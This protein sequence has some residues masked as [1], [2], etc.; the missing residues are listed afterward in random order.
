MSLTAAGASGVCSAHDLMHC[1]TQ[2]LLCPANRFISVLEKRQCNE[3]LRTINQNMQRLDWSAT[4][5][6]A[7]VV[8]VLVI[9]RQSDSTV[10]LLLAAV[11]AVIS[12]IAVVLSSSPV[13]YEILKV[14]LVCKSSG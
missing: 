10:V 12:V 14:V 7:T 2:G 6:T 1:N 4:A 8:L 3:I 9:L 5:A 11:L 13:N